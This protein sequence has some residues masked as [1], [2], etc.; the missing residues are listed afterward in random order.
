MKDDDATGLGTVTADDQKSWLG[1]NEP[2]QED[3]EDRGASIPIAP[4]LHPRYGITTDKLA[5]AQRRFTNYARMRI[6]GAGNREYSRGSKQ[7]FEDMGLHRLIDELRDELADA[8][9]YLTFID[10]QLSRWKTML[11]EK[12]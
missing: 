10:V 3:G 4:P 11:E 5:E 12:T 7:A 1:Y 8:V 9:N 2:R 6:V